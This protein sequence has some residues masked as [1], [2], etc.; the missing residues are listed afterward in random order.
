MSGSVEAWSLA[1]VKKAAKVAAAVPPGPWPEVDLGVPCSQYRP[2]QA[3]LM[4][5]VTRAGIATSMTLMGSPQAREFY[6]RYLTPGVSTAERV[7]VTR[8]EALKEFATAPET[9]REQ[10]VVL[11]ELT[12]KLPPLLDDQDTIL[13]L[14]DYDVGQNRHFSYLF[15]SRYKTPGLI[16][17][18]AVRGS[19]I[20]GV[21]R[22]D[23][24]NF[25]GP[26][27]LKASATNLGVLSKVDLQTKFSLE[28]L[29]SLDFCPGGGGNVFAQMLTVP[30]SRLEVTPHPQG[31]NYATPFLLSAKTDGV[32][33][34]TKD[35]TAQFQINDPDNDAYPDWQPW[36]SANYT[37]DNCPGVS[38]PDQADDDGDGEGNACDEGTP[39]DG[40]TLWPWPKT[41][42]GTY[43]SKLDYGNGYTDEVSF[44]LELTRKDET[45]TPN[46]D[47]GL[48]VDAGYDLTASNLV[49][50]NTGND[51]CS[52][53]ITWETWTNSWSTGG[54]G[55]N[56]KGL[57]HFNA[58]DDLKFDMGFDD[59]SVSRGSHGDCGG[60]PV[61]VVYSDYGGFLYFIDA[62]NIFAD[63]NKNLEEIH[64]ATDEVKLDLY[65]I[66]E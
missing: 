60:N 52:D 65:A 20:G 44:D 8:T 54:S 34:V 62:G 4:Q 19:D 13:N 61:Q 30:M 45:I 47:W 63:P 5:L 37:L 17:G 9:L 57:A 29:D 39:D 46:A 41:Y 58:Y 48:N 12:E 51:P 27:T 25:S 59:S 50:K 15:E 55:S 10:D 38:N 64:Y 7:P 6:F 42:R 22:D 35:V 14:E 11:D 49:W 18:D 33:P 3:K 43:S 28:V 66:D 56:L 53:P 40:L 24:R 1:S 2:N 32:T 21:H 23:V 31:G 36:T 16:A 26:F